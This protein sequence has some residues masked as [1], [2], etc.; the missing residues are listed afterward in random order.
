MTKNLL[1][2]IRKNL[3]KRLSKPLYLTSGF[4]RVGLCYAKYSFQCTNFYLLSIH[5]KPM[6]LSQIEIFPHTHIAS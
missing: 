4:K 5:L 3:L 1:E 2:D 6:S